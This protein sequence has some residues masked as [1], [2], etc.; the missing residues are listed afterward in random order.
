M[1]IRSTMKHDYTPIRL[2]KRK[3][4]AMA[5]NASKSVENWITHAFPWK[6]QGGTATLGWNLVISYKTVRTLYHT[7]RKC[8]LSHSNGNLHKNL[9]SNVHRSFFCYSPKLQTTQTCI[10]KS[11]DK[12]IAVNLSN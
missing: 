7:T 10:N 4:T 12:Q 9:N 11:L 2:S 6:W 8:T 1:Q 3:I 5:P